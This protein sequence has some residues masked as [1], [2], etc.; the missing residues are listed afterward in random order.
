MTAVVIG[1][2]FGYVFGI[3]SVGAGA[4]FGIA[5]IPLFPLLAGHRA[6]LLGPET[7]RPVLAALGPGTLVSS[8][9]TCIPH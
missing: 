4:F 1:V 2:V 5:L 6:G 3:T 8:H 7:V 9:P